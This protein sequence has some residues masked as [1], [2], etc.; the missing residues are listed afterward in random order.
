[1]E[2]LYEISTLESERILTSVDLADRQADL[3]SSQTIFKKIPW[4]I[5]DRQ[6]C[7]ERRNLYNKLSM[8]YT[9]LLNVT[10]T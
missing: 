4:S 1:M 9:H 5:S 6:I 8:A 2:L 7:Q 10:Q 3:V